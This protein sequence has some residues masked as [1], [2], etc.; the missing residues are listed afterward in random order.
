LES[1]RRWLVGIALQTRD[2]RA[3]RLIARAAGTDQFTECYPHR[4]Q[5][6]NPRFD[7]C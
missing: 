3:G 1:R 4:F 6:A 5:I 2:D 7:V